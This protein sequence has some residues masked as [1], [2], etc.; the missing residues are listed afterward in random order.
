MP[1]S[2]AASM[3]EWNVSSSMVSDGSISGLESSWR[4][5]G[6]TVTQPDAKTAQAQDSNKKGAGQRRA[7]MYPRLPQW[8]AASNGL[9]GPGG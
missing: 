6:A 9:A 3:W 2:R 4:W 1:A 7:N 8:R 5:E